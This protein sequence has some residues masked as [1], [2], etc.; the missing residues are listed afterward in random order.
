MT[1][2]Q[3][4]LTGYQAMQRTKKARTV[5]YDA[6]DAARRGEYVK[7]EHLVDEAG[8]LISEAQEEVSKVYGHSDVVYEQGSN[9]IQ[10][11]IVFRDLVKDMTRHKPMLPGL[12]RRY[13]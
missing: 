9:H 8:D 6:L 12:Y 5:L 13:S 1:Y 7:A 3:T 2:E 4:C 10:T 11:M